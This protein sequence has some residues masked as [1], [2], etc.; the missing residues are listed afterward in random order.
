MEFKGTME[1][2]LL[3]VERRLPHRG[4]NRLVVPEVKLLQ[5]VLEICLVLLMRNNRE[6]K[7]FGWISDIIAGHCQLYH[8]YSPPESRHAL[9]IYV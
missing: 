5:G 8:F 9:L 2:K 7:Q 1:S 3:A 4:I 6:S